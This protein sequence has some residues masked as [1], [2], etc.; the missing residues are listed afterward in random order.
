M[1]GRRRLQR[2]AEVLL[3]VNPSEFNMRH[4]DCG[5][6]ACAVGHA[7]RDPL[8]AAEGIKIGDSPFCNID[9]VPVFNNMV[10]YSAVSKFF[11]IP[12]SEVDAIFTVYGYRHLLNLPS[13]LD[14]RE[15]ILRYLET[16]P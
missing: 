1:T 11:G 16:H 8:L 7:A 12:E 10:G 3:H 13:A 2:L 6:A 4:W 15:K 5:T 9:G 14:V